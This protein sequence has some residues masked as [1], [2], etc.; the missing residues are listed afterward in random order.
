MQK[1]QGDP[2]LGARA[3]SFLAALRQI[4]NLSG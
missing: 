4:D 1:F 2:L 3:Q